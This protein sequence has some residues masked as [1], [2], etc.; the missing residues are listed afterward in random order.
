MARLDEW[1]TSGAIAYPKTEI[2]FHA[3][4]TAEASRIA[5]RGSPPRS[6]AAA[7][8]SSS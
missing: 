7:S 3:P 6:T 4:V 8:S 1:C 5:P 2:A